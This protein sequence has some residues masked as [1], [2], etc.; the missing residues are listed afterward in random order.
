MSNSMEDL[1]RDLINDALN[2]LIDDQLED[3]SNR[4]YDDTREVDYRVDDADKE[5]S[6]LKSE[7]RELEKRLDSLEEKYSD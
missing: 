6:A 3:I 4:A 2:E 5:I 7:V 1:I